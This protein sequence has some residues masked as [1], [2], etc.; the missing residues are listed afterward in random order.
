MSLKDDARIYASNI[1][2]KEIIQSFFQAKLCQ[3]KEFGGLDWNAYFQ[4]YT[5]EC[6]IAIEYG[7]GTFSTLRTHEQIISVAVQLQRLLTKNEIKQQLLSSL[8]GP[9]TEEQEYQM[10]EGSV[11]LVSR[12]ITMVDIGPIPYGIQGSPSLDWVEGS[13]NLKDFLAEY[14]QQPATGNEVSL[15]FDKEFNAYSLKQYTGVDI[16][17]TDN[18][19]DHLRLMNDDT[20]LCIFPHVSFL[21]SQN[22]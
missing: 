12:L 10:L 7:Q 4:Y 11:R 15:K 19:A 1:I 21:R 20:K 16:V 2:R 3:E 17:W 8:K 18:L 5:G 6:K 14:F 13:I 22:R 9:R